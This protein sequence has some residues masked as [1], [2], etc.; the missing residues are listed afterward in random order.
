M[1]AFSPVKWDILCVPNKSG[2]V[3]GTEPQ[4]IQL[5]AS[6]KVVAVTIYQYYATWSNLVLHNYEERNKGC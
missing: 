5:L 3:G 1:E 4:A 6:C 2:G